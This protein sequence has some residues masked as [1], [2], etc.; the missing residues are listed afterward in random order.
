MMW[1][2]LARRLFVAINITVIVIVQAVKSSYPFLWSS[3]GRGGSVLVFKASSYRFG[4]FALW[5]TESRIVHLIELRRTLNLSCV[6][7]ES[8]VS[9]PHDGGPRR[10]AGPGR[11]PMIPAHSRSFTPSA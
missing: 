10:E 3:S 4:V 6:V 7:R 11:D 1:T 8:R 2:A 9:R 5:K